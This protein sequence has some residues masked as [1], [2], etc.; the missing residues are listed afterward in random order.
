MKLTT[1]EP[2]H[3]ALCFESGYEQFWDSGPALRAAQSADYS[4]KNRKR[5]KPIK[6]QY[7]FQDYKLYIDQIKAQNRDYSYLTLNTFKSIGIR[8]KAYYDKHVNMTGTI[9]PEV[10]KAWQHPNMPYILMSDTKV[11]VDKPIIKLHVSELTYDA[12]NRG[13]ALGKIVRISQLPDGF[14]LTGYEIYGNGTIDHPLIIG[15]YELIDKQM[16]TDFLSN[17]FAKFDKSMYVGKPQLMWLQQLELMANGSVMPTTFMPPVEE[18][19]VQHSYWYEVTV[20]VPSTDSGRTRNYRGTLITAD[21]ITT[22]PVRLPQGQEVN[23]LHN[24]IT[25]DSELIELPLTERLDKVGINILKRNVTTLGI[26]GLVADAAS[27]LSLEGGKLYYLVGRKGS[28]KTAK[29]ELL[30]QVANVE[31]S[32]EY[33]VFLYWYLGKYGQMNMTF[34]EILMWEPPMASYEADIKHFFSY[35]HDY[36]R[37]KSFFLMIAQMV[38]KTNVPDHIKR[39]KLLVYIN[40]I[41]GHVH[42][43]MRRFSQIRAQLHDKN[44]ATFCMVHSTSE[45]LFRETPDDT[46]VLS[47]SIDSMK[48]VLSR[49]RS[50]TGMFDEA[51][52]LLYHAYSEGISSINKILPFALILERIRRL[53]SDTL[54]GSLRIGT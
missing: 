39:R 4:E 21:V 50:G 16:K 45:T 23:F 47:E 49:N 48:N 10:M 9:K 18:A 33:G 28:G 40:G 17:N 13:L 19:K 22:V 27:T 41:M 30:S 36:G 6:T 1:K 24:F 37:E 43:G 42:I 5:K 34:E 53:K 44:K 26:S 29:L 46:Y 25:A 7:R 20:S 11:K 14:D 32:D 35:I 54:F 12:L 38:A 3:L 52:L 31:D 15:N 2:I 51:E 8:V